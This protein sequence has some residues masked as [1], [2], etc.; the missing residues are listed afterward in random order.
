[1][2]TGGPFA[3]Q[4]LTG[5]LEKVL[6]ELDHQPAGAEAQQWLRSVERDLQSLRRLVREREEEEGQR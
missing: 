1:M 3:E 5:L 6:R 4:G 2:S